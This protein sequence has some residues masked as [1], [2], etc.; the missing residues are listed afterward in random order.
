MIVVELEKWIAYH[1][2]RLSSFVRLLMS[3]MCVCSFG[4]KFVRSVLKKKYLFSTSR[5][6]NLFMDLLN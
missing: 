1:H 5:R 4:L 6:F 2:S 3:C